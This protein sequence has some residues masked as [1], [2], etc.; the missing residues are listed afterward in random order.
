MKCANLR[1]KPAKK[2]SSSPS[3][4]VR[5][6]MIQHQQRVNGMNSRIN[7][8]TP[9]EVSI[10]QSHFRSLFEMKIALS[11]T[12]ARASFMYRLYCGL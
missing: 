5:R 3:P 4:R 11:L 2:L 9:R 6:V 7:V 8:T 10:A 12:A 1:W